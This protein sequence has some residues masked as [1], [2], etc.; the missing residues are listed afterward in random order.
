MGASKYNL[1]GWII[2]ILIF[3]IYSF[4]N[5]LFKRSIILGIL[6]S[7]SLVGII[8]YGISYLFNSYKRHLELAN[9][10]NIDNRGYE[11]NGL[12]EL[13]HRN[14]AYEYIYKEG[15]MSGEF[16][17]RFRCYDVHHIDGNKRNNSIENLQILTRE[18]HEK[19]HKHHRTYH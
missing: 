17:E 1:Y 15:Y 5:Y 8:S 19:I 2:F 9:T 4:F 18:E 7:L 10:I 6:I 13:V 3:G 12:N 14:I 16:T 11:R